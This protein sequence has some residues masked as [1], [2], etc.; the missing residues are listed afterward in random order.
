M[1]VISIIKTFLFF[2]THAILSRECD[3]TY[4]YTNSMLQQND[5]T[6][7][8]SFTSMAKNMLFYSCSQRAYCFLEAIIGSGM[9]LS[10][11]HVIDNILKI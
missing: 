2:Q 5:F 4:E 9:Y 10:A 7:L 1:I 6:K 11:D 8:S 3:L